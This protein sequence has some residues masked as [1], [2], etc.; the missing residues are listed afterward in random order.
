MEHGAERIQAIAEFL[1]RH[2]YGGTN[3]AGELVVEDSVIAAEEIIEAVSILSA[4]RQ[5]YM[6]GTMFLYEALKGLSSEKANALIK[7]GSSLTP[8]IV[9]ALGV[10]ALQDSLAELL[11]KNPESPQ[12]DKV[13]R[14]VLEHI[15]SNIPACTA[16]HG[17]A[18]W[19]EEYH[20]EQAAKTRKPFGVRGFFA[21]NP[22]YA[23][24]FAPLEKHRERFREVEDIIT[25]ALWFRTD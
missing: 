22:V 11:G 21:A 15:H 24:L 7:E 17:E 14:M 23:K 6:V 3:R 8:N 1:D 16:I 9:S 18:A 19:A 5:E 10:E 20:R 4:E 25:A 13:A 12:F 2:C